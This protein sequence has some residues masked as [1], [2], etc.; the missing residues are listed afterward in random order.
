MRLMQIDFYICFST[1]HFN[2][3]KIIWPIPLMPYSH[4]RSLVWIPFDVASSKFYELYDFPF[5][6]IHKNGQWHHQNGGIE[7]HYDLNDDSFF[8]STRA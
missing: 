6:F 3:M 1:R 5:S 7:S 2:R 4:S 8:L